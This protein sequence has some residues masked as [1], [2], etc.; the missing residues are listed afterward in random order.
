[1]AMARCGSP[2]SLPSSRILSGTPPELDIAACT[3]VVRRTNPD[4][5]KKLLER[6]GMQYG[7]RVLRGCSS[8]L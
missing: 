2:G 5:F 3:H 6:N 4:E 8:Q 7:E 1:M